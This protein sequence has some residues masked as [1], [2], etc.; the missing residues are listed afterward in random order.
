MK[1]RMLFTA[2]FKLRNLGIL[3]L[4]LGLAS[5]LSNQAAWGAP[6][7]IPVVP[8]II[9]FPAGMVLYLIAVGQSL[10]SKDFHD[11]FNRKQKVRQIQNLNY[12]CLKLS[13]EAKKNTNNTYL[14]KMKKVMEDKG[15][16]VNSYFNGE[17]N[18]LKEKIVEQTLNL[19]VSY[20]KLLNNF[21]VRSREL[22]GMDVSDIANRINANTRRLNF[23]KDPRAADDIK[24]VIEMDEKIIERLKD[25]KKDLERISAKLDYM[26]STVS[27]FKH[28]IISNIESEEML[29]TLETAVNEA[30]ALDTVLTERKKRERI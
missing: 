28:Q 10:L 3:L 11:D 17:R 30:S 5:V 15:D 22:S 14:L 26:E 25:E 21:C 16:I 1:A 13:N 2:L 19:V 4:T 7:G 20:L 29:E 12:S 6:I 18:Y 8:D 23:A 9:A 24:R 27:M